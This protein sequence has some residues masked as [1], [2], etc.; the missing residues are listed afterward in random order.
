MPTRAC[1]IGGTGRVAHRDAAHGANRRRTKFSPDPTR[2]SSGGRA[3]TYVSP[4]VGLSRPRPPAATT[5]Q[6]YHRFDRPGQRAGHEIAAGRGLRDRLQPATCST[7]LARVGPSTPVP[8]RSR[9]LRSACALA[10]R[11]AVRI[12][13]RLSCHAAKSSIFIATRVRTG[14]AL[15]AAE[16]GMSHAAAGRS[17]RAGAHAGTAAREGLCADTYTAIRHR[18][19]AAVRSGSRVVSVRSPH[20]PS[21][22]GQPS[23]DRRRGHLLTCAGCWPLAKRRLVRTSS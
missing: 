14:S 17:A 15:Y 20:E 5:R 16:C 1:A 10:I 7:L 13:A 3:M 11:A 2:T 9:N 8:V 6:V 22:S 18:V 19:R 23:V 4:G 21:S 12:S